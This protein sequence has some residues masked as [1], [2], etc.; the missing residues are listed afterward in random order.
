MERGSRAALRCGCKPPASRQ[1]MQ[2]KRARCEALRDFFR[3]QRLADE[4][5]LYLVASHRSEQLA[6]RLGFDAFRDEFEIERLRESNDRADD[7]LIVARREQVLDEAAVDLQ[8]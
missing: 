5:A 4:P 3:R 7:R 6:L 1:L 2:T 8:L